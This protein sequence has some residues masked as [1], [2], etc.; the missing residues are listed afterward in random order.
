MRPTLLSLFNKTC[1]L[2]SV[3]ALWCSGKRG[4][5]MVERAGF[6]FGLLCVMVFCFLCRHFSWFFL[7]WP[8]SFRKRELLE[9]AYEGKSWN[10]QVSLSLMFFCEYKW[11]IMRDKRKER[12]E[13]AESWTEKKK[14]YQ[15][16]KNIIF[17]FCWSFLGF[18]V[19]FVRLFLLYRTF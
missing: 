14:W 13:A 16:S 8:Q 9:R 1:H 4:W 19:R 10:L 12:K 6:D 18:S 17:S 11:H 3:K 15:E 7:Q 5:T 2:C